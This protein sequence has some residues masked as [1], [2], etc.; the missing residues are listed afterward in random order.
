MF[1]IM[2]RDDGVDLAFKPPNSLGKMCGVRQNILVS[3]FAWISRLIVVPNVDANIVTVR[4][5]G[6]EP[7]GRVVPTTHIQH[8]R[9]RW[10]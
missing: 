4:T 6:F 7:G 2:T 1:E 3:V 8:S 5:K 9:L 10:Q